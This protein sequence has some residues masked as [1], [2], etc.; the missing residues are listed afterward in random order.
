M[1][2]EQDPDFLASRKFSRDE[3]LT[4]WR[5]SSIQRLSDK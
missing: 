5:V 4:M 3:I 1:L 2:S